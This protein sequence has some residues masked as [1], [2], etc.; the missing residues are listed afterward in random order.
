MNFFE[1]WPGR[2]KAPQVSFLKMKQRANVKSTIDRV[3]RT[4]MKS[5]I[6]DSDSTAIFAITASKKALT[7][8][9]R[10]R[11]WFKRQFLLLGQHINSRRI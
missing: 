10:S 3:M 9:A 6:L 11:M 4:R 1:P 7:N 8:D 2:K 5:R